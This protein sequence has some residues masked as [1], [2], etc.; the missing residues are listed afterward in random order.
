LTIAA[1]AVAAGCTGPT[2]SELAGRAPRDSE[3][4]GL[5]RD[6]LDGKY[7]SLG[8][9]FGATV[10]QAEDECFGKGACT[11]TAEP[12]AG[13]YTLNVRAMLRGDEP[14]EDVAV[15]ITVLDDDGVALAERSI[16]AAHFREPL[17][18][19]NLSVGFAHD[20]DGP[21]E[22][23]VDWDGV[24]VEVDY[25]EMF[26]ARRGVI[27]SP[28]SGVLAEDDTIAMEAVDAP[29]GASLRVRCGEIDRTEA[30]AGADRFDGEFRTVVSVPAATLLDGCELPARLRV[31]VV[32]GTWTRSTSRT[33]YYAEPPPCAFDP[34]AATRVLLTG[35]EPFPADS[36]RD[37]SSE[38]AVSD[39]DATSLPGASVM[40][41][42]LPVEW[43]AAAALA[44]GVIERCDPDVVIG[45][46]QGRS[47]VDV[48]T[49]AYNRMDSSDIAGGA[50]DNRGVVRAGDPIAAGG[51]DE[52][53]TG[54]PAA[55]LVDAL[56]DRGVDASE[57]DDPGRYICNN[58]FYSIMR[59]VEG[60][61]RV[62]GFVHLPYIAR[63]DEDDRAMLQTVVATVL[64]LAAGER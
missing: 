57:S 26:R 35:F 64:E 28:P 25:L 12:G 52:L 39:F 18:Y 49:T 34:N 3:A 55:A 54:L 33:T 42:I 6:F 62:G 27:V 44:G 43:E 31:D 10:W 11:V 21:V 22:I 51:P 4:D 5:Y 58:L 19:H 40:H 63:V 61:D 2:E 56:L 17:L 24:R 53:A 1:A 50:P 14:A 48:E 7:D 9:P 15:A 47:T 32:T 45:F 29:A 37:N 30:L 20:G 38:R 60:T 16:P 36:S 59:A 23:A 13:R 8:H 46:G 41:V